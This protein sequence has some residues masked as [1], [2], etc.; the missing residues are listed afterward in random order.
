[1]SKATH[2][3][4]LAPG[5]EADETFLWMRINAQGEAQGARGTVAAAQLN[6]L[7]TRYPQDACCLLVSVAALAIH[8]VHL[9]GRHDAAGMR[10][11]PWLLEEK[12]G[13]PMQQMVAVPLASEGE[14]IWAAA[15]EQAQIAQWQAPFQ[16]AGLTL[17]RIIPDALLLPRDDDAP[18]ALRWQGGWLLRTAN[19][20]GAQ[21]DDDWLGLWLAARRRERPDEGAVRCYGEPPPDCPDWQVQPLREAFTLLA[22][23][24]PGCN[25]SLLPAPQR[26]ASSV[27][28]AP[29]YA[30]AVLLALLFVWQGLTLWQLVRQGDAL[31]QQ[32]QQQFR[33]RFPGEPQGHWQT[34]VRRALARE[35]G[36]ELAAWMAALPALPQGVTVRELDWQAGTSPLRLVLD[37]EAAGLAQAQQRLE[38][39]F[40]LA[41]QRD[42]AFM[43]SAKE[44]AQ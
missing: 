23:A 12:L 26:R 15:L 24:V 41:R 39:A 29:L 38:K 5:A 31:E 44:T 11:L 2:W 8:C 30:A 35:S 32:V 3:L 36:G 27:L 18:S 1:M 25:I 13:A 42:G 16:A 40:T 14:N 20:E 9:P 43:L 10:A 19:L 17:S 37:G 4:V 33:E 21:V 34:T 7:A 22:E 6:T 28:R